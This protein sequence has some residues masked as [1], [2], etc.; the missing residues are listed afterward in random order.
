MILIV[1]AAGIGS[2]YGGDKQREALGPNGEWITDLNLLDAGAAGFHRAILVCRGEHEAAIAE[3]MTDRAPTAV[4]VECV[5]QRADDL[6]RSMPER[7][8]PWGT[9]HA[10]LAARAKIDEPCCVINADDCYGPGTFV[11]AARLLGECSPD[12]GGLVTFR[13]GATLSPDGGVS[14]GLCRLRDGELR[15]VE[16]CTS[17][18]KSGNEASGRDSSGRETTAD[19]ATPTS[20]NT[21]CL[22]PDTVQSLWGQMDGW[23]AANPGEKNEFELPTALNERIQNETLRVRCAET[24][25]PWYGMTTRADRAAVA[26]HLRERFRPRE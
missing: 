25:E 9:A 8:R 2:R 18:A 10:L 23:L 24:M 13:L 14:R 6:P 21:W 11:A 22:H 7:E 16:E 12:L 17:L 3:R 4:S 20:L 15:S 19:L 1:L 5:S 26:A